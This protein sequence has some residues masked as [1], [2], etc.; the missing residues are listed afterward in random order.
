MTRRIAA[1]MG[2]VAFAICILVGLRAQNTFA[3]VVSNALMAMVVTFVV[4]LVVGAMA[5]KM[6]DENL[7][8]G[9][10]AAGNS[11]DSEAKTGQGDR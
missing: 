10:A 8:S 6:L 4:G 5:Q 9:D 7:A 2:L 11:A 3:T 1:M